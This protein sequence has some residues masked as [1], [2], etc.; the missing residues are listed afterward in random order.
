VPAPYRRFVHQQ[1]PARASAATV[2]YLLGVGSHQ[3]HDPMP[4]HPVMAGRR[5]NRHPPC[6]LHKPLSEPPSQPSLELGMLLEVTLLTV[7][8]PEPA[9]TPHQRGEAAAHLQV[10]DP[11]GATVPHLG[12]LEPTVRTPRPR[13][14]RFHPH[15]QPINRV[16]HHLQHP[17]TL[18]M[19]PDRHKIRHRGPSWDSAN[20]Y[21][22]DSS[23][24]STPFQGFHPPNPTF[25]RRARQI[26]SSTR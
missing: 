8:A 19:Q 10:T 26:A 17:N 16:N 20:W 6:V 3:P 21:F 4:A 2:H 5:P 23:G 13:P 14:S 15:H 12:T 9:A 7:P 24:A 11:L 22:T 1:H 18:Q 25:P